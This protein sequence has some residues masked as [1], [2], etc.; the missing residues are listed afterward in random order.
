MVKV[1]VWNE[2]LHEK[3]DEAVK[4]V[5]PN[6]IHQAIA[7]GIRKDQVIVRTATLEEPEHGLTEDVLNDTDVLIWWGHRGHD[8]VEDDIVQR[9]H[10]RVLAGM[11]LIVLHSGHFSKIFKSLMGTSCDLNV[12]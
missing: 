5:Y 3:E 8:R 11:G 7:D 9:V 10:K 4:A 2:F 6:G 1:T 12:R